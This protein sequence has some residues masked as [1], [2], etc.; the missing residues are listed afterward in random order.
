MYYLGYY[1]RSPFHDGIR[2]RAGALIHEGIW[3]SYDG[4]G[5]HSV[6]FLSLYLCQGMEAYCT[7]M[8]FVF[9]SDDVVKGDDVLNS[10]KCFNGNDFNGNNML[11]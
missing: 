8:A 2:S 10:D 1:G 4:M 7:I 6:A 5:W 3:T 9:N 11:D